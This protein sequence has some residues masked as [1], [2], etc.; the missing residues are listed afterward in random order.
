MARRKS[1]FRLSLLTVSLKDGSDLR[2]FERVRQALLVEGVVDAF[3]A[4]RP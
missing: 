4:L 2:E 1:R 3:T